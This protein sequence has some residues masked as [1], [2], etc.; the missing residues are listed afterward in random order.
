[1]RSI[2]NWGVAYFTGAKHIQLGSLQPCSLLSALCPLLSAL[3]TYKGARLAVYVELS[4]GKIL[5]H[6]H[7]TG[8]NGL[9]SQFYTV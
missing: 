4:R 5:P 6:D 3:S 2:F 9:T 7:P 8:K 1:M